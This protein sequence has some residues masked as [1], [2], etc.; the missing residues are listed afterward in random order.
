MHLLYNIK[1]EHSQ[2]G[3]SFALQRLHYCYMCVN[4]NYSFYR[5]LFSSECLSLVLF[6]KVR[7]LEAE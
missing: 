4:L 6:L 2:L 3:H 1:T 7:L 5:Q